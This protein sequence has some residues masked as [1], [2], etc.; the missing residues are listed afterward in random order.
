MGEGAARHG[1]RRGPRRA[2]TGRVAGPAQEIA[3]AV[4]SEDLVE[5]GVVGGDIGQTVKIVIDIVPVLAGG[6]AVDKCDAAGGVGAVCGRWTALSKFG[7]C[8]G[9]S[10]SRYFPPQFRQS[11]RDS[12]FIFS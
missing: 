10:T 11:K 4:V 1:E 5:A 8:H 9:I 7:W 6:D 3:G 12:A 2:G